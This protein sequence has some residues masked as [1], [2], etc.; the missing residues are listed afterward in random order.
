MFVCCEG[1]AS[2]CVNRT[3]DYCVPIEHRG[4]SS[5]EDRDNNHHVLWFTDLFYFRL[6]EC[7]RFGAVI[8]CLVQ[9][10]SIALLWF[11]LIIPCG[12]PP[13][14]F[15]ESCLSKAIS[16]STWFC[17]DEEVQT[18]ASWALS[19]P[20]TDVSVSLTNHA[21]LCLGW[22]SCSCGVHPPLFSVAFPVVNYCWC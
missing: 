14:S 3:E 1:Q 9:N 10:V 22:Y 20:N 13:T 11:S 6:G 17:A 8:L 2:W 16:L 15:A 4:W 5:V 12:L 18:V 21:F 7:S 19:L